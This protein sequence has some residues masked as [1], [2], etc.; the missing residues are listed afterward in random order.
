VTP[1]GR[2]FT[3]DVSR[4]ALLAPGFP[5]DVAGILAEAGVAPACLTLAVP[6]G[7]AGLAGEDGTVRAA[8]QELRG[9]G[10]GLALDHTGTADA[11]LDLLVSLPFTRLV[12]D[13]TLFPVVGAEPRREALVDAVTRL[14][15]ATGVET[16]VAGVREP[17]QVS[18]LQDLGFA[19]GSGPAL[20]AVSGLRLS[21]R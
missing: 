17:G 11:R 2:P 14:V 15:A 1:P 13:A 20:T 3:V 21:S 10:V 16:V 6:A 4:S 7:L 8:L 19:L 5:P 12:L 18:R 9:I